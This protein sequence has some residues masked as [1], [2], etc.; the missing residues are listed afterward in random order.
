VSV[1]PDIYEWYS[2]T[3]LDPLLGQATQS[4]PALRPLNPLAHLLQAG[5][6][7][8]L[9]GTTTNVGVDPTP[10]DARPVA[11][12]PE[13]PP[14]P[15]GGTITDPLATAGWGLGGNATQPVPAT[16]WAP[17]PP[18]DRPAAPALAHL[19]PPVGPP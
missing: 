14:P 5:N 3:I 9:Q 8:P 10:P 17:G 15:T 6:P 18:D 13:R 19:P 4:L 11:L 7:A 12:A 16:G 1:P 2:H